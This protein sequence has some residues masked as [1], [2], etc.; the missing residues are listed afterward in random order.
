MTSLLRSCLPTSS[1]AFFSSPIPVRS[2]STTS[3]LLSKKAPSFSR[4]G[5]PPLP[6][7]DQAEFDALLKA[8]ESIGASPDIVDDP[9][10]GIKA[11]DDLHRDIR[12]GP[13]PEFEGDV[14]PKTGERGGPKVDPFKA[15]DQ[16]WSYAGRV[17]DF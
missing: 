8:N 3:S 5:P 2:L 9:S 10:K 4:P 17:T 15:G 16:D 6:P 1:R 13:R 7:S 11:S 14:N 12:R